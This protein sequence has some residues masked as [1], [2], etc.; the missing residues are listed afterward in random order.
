M[1]ASRKET[2]L[3]FDS[4]GLRARLMGDDELLVQ[5]IESCVPD[6]NANVREYASAITKGDART[7]TQCIHAIRDVSQNAD[8]EALS[9]LACRIE[10]SLLAGET[11]Y[12]IENVERL[13][14]TVG[15]TL[16]AIRDFRLN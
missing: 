3:L 14:Q 12:A 11:A 6:I 5:V 9:A 7:A 2:K 13:E 4:S 8:L 1:A 15:E 10:D 16:I